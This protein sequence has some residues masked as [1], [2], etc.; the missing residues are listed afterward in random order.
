MIKIKNILWGLLNL[1]FIYFFVA[2][3]YSI[4]I[5]WKLVGCN[6]CICSSRFFAYV[7]RYTRTD[8]CFTPVY[9]AHTR[10][11]NN[12]HNAVSLISKEKINYA[13]ELHT[14]LGVRVAH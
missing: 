9:T 8:M 5:E 13:N 10:A 1:T 6:A 3:V 4:K 7:L 11:N 2:L 12:I 14:F